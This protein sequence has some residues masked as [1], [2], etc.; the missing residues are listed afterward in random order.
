ML[1]PRQTAL[2][3]MIEQSL[4][5]VGH[6]R[7]EHRAQTQWCTFLVSSSTAPARDI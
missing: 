6:P 4:Q 2:M 1:T 7:H 5:V 3:V